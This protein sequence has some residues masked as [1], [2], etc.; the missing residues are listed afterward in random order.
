M[1]SSPPQMIISLPVHTV[2][3]SDRPGGTSS[4]DAL[5][6]RSSGG[7]GWEVADD[8]GRGSGA[9]VSETTD[10]LQRGSLAAHQ[11]SQVT[12]STCDSSSRR[13][14]PLDGPWIRS[15]LEKELRDSRS[16][17]SART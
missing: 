8:A 13:A 3:C 16:A 12:S 9:A 15:S 7:H 5:S 10:V 1:E 4:I 11:S 17:R 2:V 6:Q 14:S